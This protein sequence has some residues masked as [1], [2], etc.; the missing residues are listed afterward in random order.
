MTTSSDEQYRICKA[1]N[2]KNGVEK[3]DA[4]DEEFDNGCDENA[5]YIEA[6]FKKGKLRKIYNTGNPMNSNDRLNSL[7]LDGRSKS[8]KSNKKGKYG[9]GG[10]YSR[11][12]LAGQGKQIITT[13]DGDDVYQCVIDLEKLQDKEICNQNC[14]T[15]E[16]K[17]RPKWVKLEG[18]NI[19]PY[20]QGVTKEY[21][22]DNISTKFILEEVILHL[23]KKYNKNIK[24]GLK[25][26]IIWDNKNYILPDIYNYNSNSFSIDVYSNNGFVDY[27]S[28]HN[29]KNIKC[30][31][32]RLTPDYKSTKEGTRIGTYTLNVDYP[33]DTDVSLSSDRYDTDAAKMGYISTQYINN[34]IDRVLKNISNND[35][36]IQLNCGENSVEYIISKSKS[37][38]KNDVETII[39]LFVPG[40]TISMD[41]NTLCYKE[42]N[43]KLE[44]S[45]GG[46]MALKKINQIFSVDLKFNSSKSELDLSQEDKNK[47]ELP[48]HLSRII[49]KIIDLTQKDINDRL[50]KKYKELVTAVPIVNTRESLGNTDSSL[51]NTD[52]S[53]VNTD[54]SLVN[55]DE[56]LVDTAESHVDTGESLGNMGE[57]LVNTDESHVDTDE[58]LGDMEES[59]GDTD[60]S[61]VNTDEYLVNTDESLGDMEESQGDTD[62][63]LVNTDEY[64]VNTDESHVN[65]DESHVDTD[66]SLG[67]MEE[68]QG[69]TDES[70]V[71][72]DESFDNGS[73][74]IKVHAY[75][76][77]YV[78][79]E[80]ATLVFKRY[81]DMF[82]EDKVKV[83]PIN[84]M[85]RIINSTIN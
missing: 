20:S 80:E 72:T 13:K 9:I 83:E 79:K 54:D 26:M 47:V 22:G 43:R 5:Y 14:W 21:I 56:S 65:T 82:P 66:E 15:G 31:I 52:E 3:Q 76:K 11:C 39:D 75:Y 29:D 36:Y 34:N 49:S 40:I 8:T 41:N 30:S 69:D 81:L 84:T 60:E 50:L 68:S 45:K 59:Q 58:S 71:N 44:M 27:Y 77:G 53:L 25:I 55:T 73:K 32:K 64:L 6:T 12:K 4:I 42:F 17:Y 10:F 62:E 19:S 85:Y 67:D 70:L 18:G 23:V 74:K 48:K 46:D 37:D 1:I 38:I 57:S 63:S 16:H 7:T 2:G 78:K 33:L 51:V 35:E 28:E 61:L 24:N